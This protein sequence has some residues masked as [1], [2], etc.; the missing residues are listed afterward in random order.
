MWAEP[1]VKV[2]GWIRYDQRSGAIAADEM[3]I[4]GD[5]FATTLAG[6]LLWND[7]Q[8][9]LKLTGPARLKMNEVAGRL[10]QLIGVPITAQGIHQTPLEIQVRR[11][12]DGTVGLDIA[13]N[14][15]WERSEIGGVVM[16]QALIPI[17]LTETSVDISPTM[18]PVGDGRLNLSGQVHYRPGPLWMRLERGSGAQ[19]IRLTPEM[20]DKWLKYIAPLAANTARIDGTL[21]VQLD[22]ALIVIDQPEQSRVVGRLN[23]AGVE[24]SSGPM[25]NQIYGGI[26]QL[27]MLARSVSSTASDFSGNHTLITMPAQTVDFVVDRGIVQHNRMFFNVDR[28]EVITSGQVAMDGRLNIVAQVPLDARWLGSDLQGL[29]GQPVT[30]PIDGTLSRPSLDSSGVRQ[31]VAELGTM[32]VQ[33]TAENYLQKQLGKGLDKL[34]GR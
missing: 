8:G 23:I 3:Q 11:G 33:Q 22:E 14:L 27:R 1:T 4:A 6:S 10:S 19:S 25:A 18:I 26:E 17:R 31:V 15:G 20:T 13:A 7:Q 32:A 5:W 24:M 9:E 30:L 34:F 2:D 21:G 12:R 16:G 29:A 28:A